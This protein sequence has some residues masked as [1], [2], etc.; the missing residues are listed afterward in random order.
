MYNQEPDR[1]PDPTS[2]SLARDDLPVI[3]RAL[4]GEPRQSAPD[5]AP[6]PASV[7]ELTV[8]PAP[9][10]E[11]ADPF[12][13]V[14]TPSHAV[15]VLVEL[16]GGGSSVTSISSLVDLPPLTG[17]LEIL[18]IGR[19]LRFLNPDQRLE[20]LMRTLDA[21]MAREAVGEIG[22]TTVPH[23]TRYCTD[24]ER[25]A[26]V[27]RAIERRE[28]NHRLVTRFIIN[29]FR[30]CPNLEGAAAL[31]M[32]AGREALE[33]LNS[34]Q[35]K[36]FIAWAVLG[37]SMRRARIPSAVSSRIDLERANERIAEIVVALQERIRISD[38]DPTL[39]ATDIAKRFRRIAYEDLNYIERQMKRFRAT[40]RLASRRTKE[41]SP[42]AAVR[43]RQGLASLMVEMMKVEFSFGINMTC[44]RT[45]QGRNL[46]VW[47][48]DEVRKIHELLTKFVP[49]NL[50]L[51][52]PHLREFRRIAGKGT[53]N[54]FR[55]TDG[56]IHITDDGIGDLEFARE[57][58]S[59]SPLLPIVAHEL[60]HSI[61]IGQGRTAK[62]RICSR[63]GRVIGPFDPLFS[64]QEFNDLSGW[65]AYE[66]TRFKIVHHHQ[67]VIIDGQHHPIDAP[68]RFKGDVV[69]F[70]HD[71]GEKLLYSHRADAMFSVRDYSRVSPWEDSAE[72]FTEYVL[73]PKRLAQFAP[74][75]FFFWELHLGV[76]E[77][78]E[79]LYELAHQKL[80]HLAAS[81]LLPDGVRPGHPT[82]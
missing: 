45:Q 20:I 80:H 48:T 75:K 36:E 34:R 35:I 65:R 81:P 18:R 31:V 46:R 37:S 55:N 73:M 19:G 66:S 38:S 79:W 14:T 2:P 74:W 53:E 28:G 5:P 13:G 24:R 76:H 23:L 17:A 21:M 33:S 12:A 67:A 47:K 8:S 9:A 1:S 49:E 61:Q 41:G 10:R 26:L 58:D 56:I 68:T 50:T 11:S 64:P 77:E 59:R 51:F 54:G 42:E 52:T 6:A 62:T 71:A 72:S 70:Q 63:E 3:T 39:R 43:R 15:G 22:I 25:V 82:R 40:E 30:C 78:K 44:E 7:P 69:V 32:G 16:V 29:L 4:A 60:G 27:T 57:F